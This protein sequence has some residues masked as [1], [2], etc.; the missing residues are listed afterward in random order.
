MKIGCAVVLV[1]LLILACL[2]KAGVLQ[3]YMPTTQTGPAIPP[4]CVAVGQPHTDTHHTL[5]L[6]RCGRQYEVL[7]QQDQGPTYVTALSA[8]FQA[9]TIGSLAYANFPFQPC[10]KVYVLYP[11]GESPVL[12]GLDKC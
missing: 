7:G 10:V 8:W 1:I 6:V 12:V 5:Q 4:S 3:A 9:G 11:R 2:W